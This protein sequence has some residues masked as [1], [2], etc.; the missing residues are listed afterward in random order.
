VFKLQETI[1]ENPIIAAVRDMSS[2]P[3]AL[4]SRASAIFLLCGEICSLGEAVTAAHGAGKS[5]FLHI[6]LAEGLGRDKA[7][8]K[9]LAQEVKPEGIITTRSHLIRFAK[10][11]DLFT[12]QR[13]FV[14]DSL[15]LRTGIANVKE[16]G[17]DALECLPGIM[18]RVLSRLTRELSQ[19]VI[20]G[21]LIRS[22]EEIEAILAAGAVAVSLSEQTLWQ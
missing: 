13:I 14:L 11:Y 12:I 9:F 8:I 22:R 7:A 1:K 15:S 21:G 19:P 20:A 10:G 5:I 3:V 16:T 4:K 2:L 18:P 17:P 6:D